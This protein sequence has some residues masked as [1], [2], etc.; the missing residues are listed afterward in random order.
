MKCMSKNAIA[1]FPAHDSTEILGSFQ[2]LNGLGIRCHVRGLA[3]L[4]QLRI[5][6]YHC[7]DMFNVICRHLYRG[8]IHRKHPEAMSLFCMLS[9]KIAHFHVTK[10]LASKQTEQRIVL[11]FHQQVGC[12]ETT[13][14]KHRWHTPKQKKNNFGTISIVPF[15]WASLNFYLYY[16]FCLGN[17]QRS[18]SASRVLSK[19]VAVCSIS[20]FR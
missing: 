12:G 2:L 20:T 16:R 3:V 14:T 13:R 15:L 10:S 5:S 4:C 6:T 17:L 9:M 18:S 1:Q 11:G 7:F 8:N 19:A